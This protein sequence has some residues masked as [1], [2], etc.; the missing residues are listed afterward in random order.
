MPKMYQNTFG[1]RAPPGPAGGACALPRSP[2]RNGVPTSKG[3][4]R[5]KGRG[6]TYKRREEWKGRGNG[7]GGEGIPP[8]I[9]VSGMD[10]GSRLSS[11]SPVSPLLSGYG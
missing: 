9:K 10:T 8:K 5:R 6:P 3:K 7:K 1:G 4:K 11:I 2:S